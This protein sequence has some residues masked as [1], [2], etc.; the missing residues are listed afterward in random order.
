SGHHASPHLRPPLAR[1]D[2][3]E[4]HHLHAAAPWRVVRHPRAGRP[5]CQ[6]CEMKNA[7]LA[8]ACVACLSATGA[9]Q[10]GARIVEW[11]AY[12]NDQGG[13]KYSP[14]TQINRDTVAALRPAWEWKTGE[15]PLQQFG[16][17]PGAFE[18]TP[19]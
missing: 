17:T 9:G 10:K 4:A 8:A 18:N 13:T 12:G 15:T 6:T 3:G 7:L 19:I 1:G 16:T 2:A 5:P 11:P 14:L